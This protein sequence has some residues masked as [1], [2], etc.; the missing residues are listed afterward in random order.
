MKGLKEK[1]VFQYPVFH[2]LI[3]MII[4]LMVFDVTIFSTSVAFAAD[5]KDLSDKEQQQKVETAKNVNLSTAI[6]LFKSGN[7]DQSKD[8]FFVSKNDLPD[9]PIPSYYLGLIYVKHDN[10][11]DAI[12]EWKRYLK[13]DPK[14]ET[15]NQIRQYLTVIMKEDARR[16]ASS[17][18]KEESKL[19]GEKTDENTVAVT[20]FH[21]IGSEGLNPLSK[22]IT[23]MLIT[24][25]SQV[26][27][28]KVV[29]REKIQAMFDEMKLADT[30]LVEQ[31]TVPKMGKLLHARNITTGS[32]TDITDVDLQ[33]TSIVF[34]TEKNKEKGIHDSKG[35]LLEFFELEKEVA[36]AILTTLKINWDNVPEEAKLIHTKNYKAFLN[37]SVGLDYLDKEDYEKAKVSL[38]KAVELDPNFKLAKEA[39]LSIPIVALTVA[40]V[41]ASATSAAPAIGTAAAVGVTAMSAGTVLAVGGTAAAVAVGTVVVGAVTG[42][43]DNYKN[44]SWTGTYYNVVDCIGA[45]HPSGGWSGTIDNNCGFR[46]NISTVSFIG[47]VSGTSVTGDAS[48]DCGTVSISGTISGNTMSNGIISGGITGNWGGKKN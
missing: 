12:T 11:K 46:F 29:E 43:C 31:S 18:A 40:S 8:L 7:E 35:K 9:N 41:V 10:L 32:Y 14:S 20:Y 26:K 36:K 28:L 17:S 25:I 37:Y 15:S 42:G 44:T 22:G 2:Y 6:D 13:L 45:S 33:I 1:S 38:K 23:A 47:K 48:S 24:D 39:Y 16:F 4:Y 19:K 21:N 34:E 27:E 5:S 3:W 30:G